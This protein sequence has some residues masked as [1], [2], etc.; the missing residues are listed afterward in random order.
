MNFFFTFSVLFR[1]LLFKFDTRCRSYEAKSA[2][3]QFYNSSF[4]YSPLCSLRMNT[5]HYYHSVWEDTQIATWTELIYIFSAFEDK[6]MWIIMRCT[7]KHVF[8]LTKITPRTLF[9]FNLWSL[10]AELKWYSSRILMIHVSWCV[11]ISSLSNK[12]K[13]LLNIFQRQNGN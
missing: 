9:L 8:L 12:G 11:N 3:H 13:I 10:P 2:E 7:R 4:P 6:K 5:F 1:W